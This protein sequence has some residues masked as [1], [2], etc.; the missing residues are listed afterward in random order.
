MSVYR[1]TVLVVDS[2]LLVIIVSI[3]YVCFATQ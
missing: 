2:G 3:V 1:E